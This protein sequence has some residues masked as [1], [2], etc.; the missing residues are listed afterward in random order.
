[1]APAP[2]AYGD[3]A[4]FDVVLAVQRAVSSDG[5]PFF[6]SSTTISD[7]P[8]REREKNDCKYNLLCNQASHG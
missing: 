7:T 1:M 4:Q 8:H 6:A 5:A 2:F 3:M